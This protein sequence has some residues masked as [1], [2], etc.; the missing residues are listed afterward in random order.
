MSFDSRRRWILSEMV[1][2]R[3]D[4]WKIRKVRISENVFHQVFQRWKLTQKN[5]IS[6]FF[7]HAFFEK[8][9]KQTQNYTVGKLQEK[10]KILK[11]LFFHSNQHKILI[12]GSQS[13]GIFKPW[14]KSYEAFS[15]FWPSA[16]LELVIFNYVRYG[17]ISNQHFTPVSDHAKFFESA[18]ANF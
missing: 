2:L 17:Y 8:L 18:H 13:F 5:E 12:R 15:I 6:I 4:P 16:I 11:N 1:D 7:A 10:M 14:V 9:L 3:L